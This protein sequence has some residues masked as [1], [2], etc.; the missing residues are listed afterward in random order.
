M[1]GDVLST[2]KKVGSDEVEVEIE[3][4]QYDAPMVYL[5]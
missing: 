3:N 1:E 4:F 2:S 5:S